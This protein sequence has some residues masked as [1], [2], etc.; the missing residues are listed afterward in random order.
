MYVAF[1]HAGRQ[2]VVGS[3]DFGLKEIAGCCGSRHRHFSRVSAMDARIFFCRAIYSKNMETAVALLLGGVIALLLWVV[4]TGNSK[5]EDDEDDEPANVTI[6]DARPRYNYP[7]SW[8]DSPYYVPAWSYGST[9]AYRRQHRGWYPEAHHRPVISQFY[10]PGH[11]ALPPR[12]MAQPRPSHVGR[13]AMS[14]PI[15]PS[16]SGRH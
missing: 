12:L 6:V 2:A 14:H 11:N 16:R 3:S 1:E 7:L 13:I 10:R 15:R 8:S 4:L 9:W 5:S